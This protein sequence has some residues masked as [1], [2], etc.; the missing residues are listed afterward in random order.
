MMLFRQSL[1]SRKGSVAFMAAT[2]LFA[3]FGF[4]AISVDAGYTYMAYNKLQAATEAAALAG[5]KDIGK[6]GNPIVTANAYSSVAGGNNKIP[7]VTATMVTGY[8][9]LACFSGAANKGL[10]CSTNQTPNTAANAILVAQTAIV[11]LTFAKVV[12]IPSITVS[13]RATALAGGQ[14]LPP[15][16]VAFVLDTTASMDSADS[17]CGKTRLACAIQGFKTLLGELWPCKFGQT[18]NGTD[19]VDLV[20]LLQFPPVQ[21]APT[22]GSCGNL[23]TVA[24]AGITGKTN[25]TTSTGQTALRFP[26]PLPPFPTGTAAGSSSN[27]TKWPFPGQVTDMK[28]AS[29]IKAGTYISSTTATTAVMSATPAASVPAQEDIAVWP[30]VYQLLPLSGDYR[31]SDTAPLNSSSNLIKCLNSLQAPGGFGSYYAD[32]INQAQTILTANA[33]TGARNVIILLSD[34]EANATA[35]NMVAQ[36][37]SSLAKDECK[38]AV[39]AAQNAA[40]N[41]TSVYSVAYG[42]SKSG[43]TT[44]SGS[45]ANACYVMGQIAN[46][47]GSTPGTYANDPTKFYS[48]N[49]NGCQ[50]TLPSNSA[51]SLNQVFKNIAYSLT[52]PRLLPT[53]CFASSRPSYC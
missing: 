44:D 13:A 29:K 27:V 26:S 23:T 37:S 9:A 39:T 43:C 38:A 28:S 32:A 41:G 1:K 4:T 42:A 24:Y 30:P 46:L 48:D 35:S 33:R 2:S 17:A 40:K 21:K 16:N 18:C 15:L 3:M 51:L 52:S 12:G 45:Y 11:P 6:G 22:G 10:A 7:G 19:P 34:G 47:P 25:N 50:A 5:A 31:T 36:G 20:T 14:A 49:A 8:P 53:A